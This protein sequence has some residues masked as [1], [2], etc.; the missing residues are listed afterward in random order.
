MRKFVFSQVRLM[1]ES[2]D[3]NQIRVSFEPSYISAGM[4]SPGD[5]GF[6]GFV[7]DADCCGGVIWSSCCSTAASS[8][9]SSF[10]AFRDSI[11]APSSSK[12]RL[13]LS[14]HGRRISNG[15]VVVTLKRAFVLLSISDSSSVDC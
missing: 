8:S 5:T 7:E 11:S 3:L 9:S 2:V 12:N 15:R 13:P 10:C 1:A 14:C 6:E 4:L